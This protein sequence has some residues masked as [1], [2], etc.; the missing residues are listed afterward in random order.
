MSM[1]NDLQLC[2]NCKYAEYFDF[3]DKTMIKCNKKFKHVKNVRNTFLTP[4]FSK[5]KKLSAYACCNFEEK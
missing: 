1:R 2:C 4:T 5:F 3:T